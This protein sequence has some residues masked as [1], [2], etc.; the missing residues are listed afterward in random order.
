MTASLGF[1]QPDKLETT[2]ATVL[3]S[4]IDNPLP[5]GF[6]ILHHKEGVDLLPANIE[7]SD[8]EVSLVNTM[9]HETILREFLK[10]V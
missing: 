3:S 7:L 4:I 10:E 8:M 2:L 5:D 9:S 6:G 1:R